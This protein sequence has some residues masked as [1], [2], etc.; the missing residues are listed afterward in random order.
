MVPLEKTINNRQKTPLIFHGSYIDGYPFPRLVSIGL[1]E[2]KRIPQEDGYHFVKI[3][4]EWVSK[5]ALVPN[6]MFTGGNDKDM[7]LERNTKTEYKFFDLIKKHREN[8]IRL[9]E[10]KIF[11]MIEAI[12]VDKKIYER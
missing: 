10:I 8:F 6:Q 1:M 4:E 11:Y 12:H 7:D 3:P 5:I 2:L 9:T